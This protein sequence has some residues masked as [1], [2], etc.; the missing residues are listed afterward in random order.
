[1]AFAL[2]A[3]CYAAFC[4]LAQGD[5]WAK[6][7][8]INTETYHRGGLHEA[9]DL[10]GCESEAKA[11]RIEAIKNTVNIE[12]IT[13]SNTREE[14]QSISASGTRSATGV[15]GS[16]SYTTGSGSSGS[17]GITYAGVRWIPVVDKCTASNIQVADGTDRGW[18]QGRAGDGYCSAEVQCKL[19]FYTPMIDC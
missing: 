2:L 8:V 16:G 15:S 11:A 3:L 14:M 9:P 12:Q 4:P 19:R 7:G 5:C 1:M 13:T 18:G 17:Q 10:N 6:S